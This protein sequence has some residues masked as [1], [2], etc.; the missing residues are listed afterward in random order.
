M[1]LILIILA[2]AGLLVVKFGVEDI[3]G[4]GSKS[5]VIVEHFSNEPAYEDA[6]ENENGIQNGAVNGTGKGNGNGNGNGA[7]GNSQT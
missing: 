5:D 3:E 6:I 2:V 4:E 1:W 7:N